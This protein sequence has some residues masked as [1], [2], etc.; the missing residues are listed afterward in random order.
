LTRVS[1]WFEAALRCLLEVLDSFF[2]SVFKQI[3]SQR[4]VSVDVIGVLC[5]KSAFDSLEAALPPDVR[6][7]SALPL[8]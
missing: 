5:P 4:K 8:W 7:G 2:I 3:R 1:R 6:Q